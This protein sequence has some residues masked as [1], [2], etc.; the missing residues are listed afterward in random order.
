[1]CTDLL[2]FFFF[3]I[4]FHQLLKILCCP[5]FSGDWSVCSEKQSVPLELFAAA[6]IPSAN[7]SANQMV[8]Q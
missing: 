3:L 5:S 2:L 1:M 6:D 4:V 7:Q 8:N